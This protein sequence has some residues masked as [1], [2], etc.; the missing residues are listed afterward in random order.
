LPDPTTIFVCTTCRRG[1]E[2]LEPIEE[3]SGAKLFAL[4]KEAARDRPDLEILG[5]ECLLNCTRGCNIALRCDGK[6][7]YHFGDLDPSMQVANIIEIATMHSLAA[8]GD[9]PWGKRPE[10]IK[11]KAVS[12]IPPLPH[13]SSAAPMSQK[14]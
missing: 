13:R 1:T 8:D 3:R 12:R 2:A 7:S 6:W 14:V 9:V 5:V 10:E 4:V 11:R